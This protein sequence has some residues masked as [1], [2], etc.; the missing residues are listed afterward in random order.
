MAGADATLTLE[1]ICATDLFRSTAP[2]DVMWLPDGSGFLYRDSVDGRDGLW[3][4]DVE[5]GTGTLVVDW[6]S[7]QERLSRLR[8]DYERPSMG[9]PNRHRK[10]GDRPTLSPDGRWYLGVARDD[11]FMIDLTTGGVRFLTDH[12]GRELYPVFSPNGRRVAFVRDGDLYW[13]ELTSGI[14]HRVTSRGNRPELFN[15]VADWVHE[16]ELGITRSFW[17]SP[18]SDRLLFVEYDL[19]PV[20]EVPIVDDLTRVP[21]VEWQW[22]PKAGEANA[23]VR[24][25]VADAESG[26]T[27]QITGGVG[28]GYLARAGWLPDGS[29]VWFQTL[30]RPQNRLELRVAEPNSDRSRRVV[31]ETD[32]AWVNVRDD[33]T[34]VASD[35]FVWS[36]ERDGWRHLYLYG[37]DGR[38]IR[39]LTAGDWQVERVYGLDSERRRVIFQANAEDLRERHVYSVALDGGALRLLTEAPGTHE[40]ELSP[41]GRFF[42]DSHSTAAQPP[43]LELYDVAGRR[44]GT[45]D[46]G[47]I[48]ALEEVRFVPPEFGTVVADDGEQLY[49]WMFRPP[50]FDPAVRYPVLVY[51]YGGPHGQ[52]VVNKWGGSRLLYFNLLAREGL[53]VFSVDNRGSWGRGHAFEAKVHRRL[54]EW[55][56]RDQL[57]GVRFLV[58]LPYVDAERIG[59]YGG[60]Y[61]GY[62]V[63]TCMNRAPN[64]FKVGIAYAPVTDWRLY[65]TIY[66]ERYMG[67]PQDNPDGFRASSTLESAE[68]LAGR[69]LICH[70]AMDN[71]VHLQNTI[72]IAERY[73]RSGKLIDLM[74]YQR[75][76]HGIRLSDHRL[77]FHRLKTEFI[78]R[79]LLHNEN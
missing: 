51:V 67:R 52:T 32:D 26:E 55:E 42:L 11:L 3:R 36:S 57:A 18:A 64:R 9:D 19:A 50:D 10:V 78:R 38:L 66:T 63:L 46:E 53:I 8:P 17:W 21:R 6:S 59:V 1:N 48:P 34:F 25:L 69:L 37:L 44:I 73:L 28:D 45:I 43:R 16:E 2:T 77:H 15:G 22:Y 68:R 75:V 76:R 39:R 60:S 33:L 40:A 31:L 79:H 12:P 47:I 54:G 58:G 29:A 65:D 30:D 71:N 23:T 74:I 35:R 70:G 41:N 49:S 61:G 4:Y 5:A 27:V 7:L 72:Q 13:I 20:S 62:M 14:E 24:L 56:L